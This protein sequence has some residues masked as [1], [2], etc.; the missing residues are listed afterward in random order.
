MSSHGRFSNDDSDDDERPDSSG[1]ATNP[2]AGTPLEGLLGGLLGGQGGAPGSGP[3]GFGAGMPDLSALMGQ[4]QSLMQPYDGP[5]NWQLATDTAR[6]TVAAEKDP[7]PSQREQDAVADAV[8]LADHWLDEVTDLDSGVTST[9]AWSRAEWVEQTQE[10]WRALVTPVAGNVV[11]GMDEALPEEMK[12]MAG[13]FL[14]MMGKASGAMFGAQAGQAIGG[15]AAEVLTASDVGLPL[16]PAGRAALVTSNVVAF[17]EGLGVGDDDLR[18]YLALREAAHQRLFAGVP[19]LRERLLASVAEVARGT[20]IDASAIEAKLS[21]LD[22]TNPAG[23][24]EALQNGLFEPEQ[25]DAQ[26]AAALR[27]ETLLALVEGWIDEVVAQAA[28]ERMPQAAQLQEAVRRRRASGGPAESTFATLV[29]LDLRPRRL[30]DASTLWGSLRTRQGV[31]ARDAVWTHPD[32]LP[33]PADLDDPLGFRE[34]VT[35]PAELSDEEFD[36]ALNDLL[37][38]ETGTDDPDGTAPGGAGS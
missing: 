6:R 7:S 27:L 14:A 18:L 12:A 21:Q 22:P 35:A 36:A 25:T 30:R 1:E 17:G 4:M 8:R 34:S 3:A 16:G 29:G 23:I 38:S 28:G 13:P 37:A 15:L 10:S 11:A 19:W 24:Q 31:E 9:A 20:R 2:F 5:V 32:L 26:K 33:T